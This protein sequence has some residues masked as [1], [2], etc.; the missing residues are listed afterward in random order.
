MLS[1]DSE[2]TLGEVF[3][4]WVAAL[5]DSKHPGVRGKREAI[6][7]VFTW[8]VVARSC[9]LPASS[10]CRKN[11]S[12][13]SKS[14]ALSL[15]RFRCCSVRSGARKTCELLEGR[16]REREDALLPRQARC[17]VLYDMTFRTVQCFA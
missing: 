10:C 8:K 4:P 15:T 2:E 17:N 3:T 9:H 7:G 13:G 12:S 11:S 5:R 1:H 16:S 6:K 14:S